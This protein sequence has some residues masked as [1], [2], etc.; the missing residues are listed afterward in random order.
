ML[1]HALHS[2]FSVLRFQTTFVQNI[3]EY[4]VSNAATK[5]SSSEEGQGHHE[6]II[7]ALTFFNK[8][9]LWEQKAE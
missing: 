3:N 4:T 8:S 5:L 9:E 1:E 6:N 7:C 2:L